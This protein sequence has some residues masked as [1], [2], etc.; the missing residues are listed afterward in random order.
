MESPHLPHL[1]LGALGTEIS[2]CGQ[3]PLWIASYFGLE[4]GKLSISA[5][6]KLN[7]GAPLPR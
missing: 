5:D 3:D 6:V 1:D 7:R 4:G 2:S